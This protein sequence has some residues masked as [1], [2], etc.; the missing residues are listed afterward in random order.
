MPLAIG[1]AVLFWSA[2]IW[3]VPYKNT[4]DLRLNAWQLL[5]GNSFFLAMLIFVLGATI[6]VVRLTSGD[7]TSQDRFSLGGS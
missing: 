2:P 7:R 4:S 3:W 6:L 5:A 1:T